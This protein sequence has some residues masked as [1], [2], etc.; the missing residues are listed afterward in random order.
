MLPG[1]RCKVFGSVSNPEAIRLARVMF[2]GPVPTMPLGYWVGVQYDEKVGK[3]DGSINGRRYFRCPPG[4][5]GFVRPSKV[6]TMADVQRQEQEEAAAEAA[7]VAR[8]AEEIARK[9]AKSDEKASEK[10]HVTT[11]AKGKVE[12]APGT[13]AAEGDAAFAEG[14]VID[15]PMGGELQRTGDAD[16]VLTAWERDYG[17]IRG[18]QAAAPHV[19]Y[20]TGTGVAT[21]IVGSLAQFTIIACDRSGERCTK[22][23][24]TFSCTMRGTGKV[25]DSQPALVRTK[26]IDRGDGT[27]MCE[28]RP[29]LT[30]AFSVSVQLDGFHIRDSPYELSVIT[31][32]PVA[33]NCIVRGDALSRAVSRTPA[34]FEILFV[35]AI[36][37]PAQAEDIDVFVETVH[38]CLAP[39][40]V[41]SPRERSGRGER[42]ERGER[43]GNGAGSVAPCSLVAR[44]VPLVCSTYHSLPCALY[45][46]RLWVEC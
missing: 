22:G 27:Y 8:R 21:A 6:R 19:S 31:L 18:E 7:R 3:N 1:D 17:D 34:K 36:G 26:V 9:A 39:F 28:Y 40:C 43:S 24:D 46:A 12:A 25:L 10:K 41:P 38:M 35:D 23:G 33:A 30:G 42:G 20:A 5:G 13:A 15:S 44:P 29:W 2:V 37:H 16:A 32:R 45:R 14:A 4:H 11:K